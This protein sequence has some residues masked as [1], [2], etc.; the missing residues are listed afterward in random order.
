MFN[1]AYVQSQVVAGK[2]DF[3]V[4]WGRTWIDPLDVDSNSNWCG[5]FTPA[6]PC[7]GFDLAGRPGRSFLKSQ[8][9]VSAVVVYHVSRYL[10][11][12]FD[13]FLAD[14]QWQQGE[15]QIVNAFNLGST[16]TW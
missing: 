5:T 6:T 12:A 10:H 11:F 13:Y 1:G 9:G 16:L 15:K 4:G 2:F 3:N 14:V 8:M 7:S